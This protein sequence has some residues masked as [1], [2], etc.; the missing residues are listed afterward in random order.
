LPS[1][2]KSLFNETI[3]FFG[4]HLI[5]LRVLF[6]QF[7]PFLFVFSALFGGL[8]VEIVDFIRNNKGSLRVKP[9]G[10]LVSP[11]T[12]IPTFEGRRK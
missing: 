6:K 2:R 9:T 3:E 1:F 4:L 5:F 7:L 8:V 11:S 10:S 12:R